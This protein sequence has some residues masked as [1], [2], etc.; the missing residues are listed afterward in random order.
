MQPAKHVSTTN[1]HADFNS[2]LVNL[3]DFAGDSLDGWRVE[4]VLLA[5]HEGFAGYLNHYPFVG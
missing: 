4:P 1:N 3:L 2:Q 5:A